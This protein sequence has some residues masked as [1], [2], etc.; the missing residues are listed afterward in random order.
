MRQRQYKPSTRCRKC[1]TVADAERIH[2]AAS[3]ATP[4]RSPFIAISLVVGA[5]PKPAILQANMMRGPRTAAIA[6]CL[7]T[8]VGAAASCTSSS[9]TPTARNSVLISTRAAPICGTQ[10][11]I[12][13]ANQT[14]AIATIK[15]G[16]NR[17]IIVGAGA[18]DNTRVVTTGPTYSTTRGTFN[19]LGGTVYGSANTFYGG[20]QTSIT[21][22]NNA[23]MQ[24][25]MFN[26]ETR[27]SRTRWMRNRHLDRSGRRR[28]IPG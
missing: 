25:V 14:A 27:G 22:G 16:Y 17:F 2:R 26:P 28:S 7:A 19:T 12:A 11:A 6:L 10:G 13:V 18:Q 23:Q 9:V 4:A 8:A 3:A 24:V 15:Q 5:S 1:S 20:Q 21:G